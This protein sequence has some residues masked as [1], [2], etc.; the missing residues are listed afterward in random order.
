MNICAAEGITEAQRWIKYFDSSTTNE[1]FIL[2]VFAISRKATV[3]FV[4]SV[5]PSVSP[6]ETTRPP[7]T[8]FHKI[9]YL[10]IF[11][12]CVEKD[13]VSS[14]LSRMAILTAVIPMCY[15]KIFKI[16]NFSQTQLFICCQL[17]I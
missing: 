17:C 5:W 1:F 16:Y 12:K 10:C 2:G 15:T 6:H 8:G 9:I 3:N 7:L 11:R 14:S 4:M 13:Q